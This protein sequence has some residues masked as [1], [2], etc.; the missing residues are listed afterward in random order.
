M[1]K[2]ISI[3]VKTIMVKRNNGEKATKVKKEKGQQ[4]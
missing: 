3:M 4:Q 2:I 1:V